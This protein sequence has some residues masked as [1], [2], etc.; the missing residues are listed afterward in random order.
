MV[1][2]WNWRWYNVLR[3]STALTALMRRWINVI[4]VD[5]TTQQRC[6]ACGFRLGTIPQGT[7]RCCDVEFNVATT[8]CAQW[9]VRCDLSQ[10]DLWLRASDLIR[11]YWRKSK[12]R[13]I[14]S[15]FFTMPVMNLQISGTT[16][17]Q[18][19]LSDIWTLHFMSAY[20]CM[21]VHCSDLDYGR[22]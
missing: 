19:P 2:T 5:S 1:S 14:T 12:W 21:Y 11:L 8:S 20:C 9:D 18:R 22:F 10:C 7:R 4:D 3:L 17:R 16:I 13:H 6:V 15:S